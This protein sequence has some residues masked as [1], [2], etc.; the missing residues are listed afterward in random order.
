MECKK[1]TANHVTLCTLCLSSLTWSTFPFLFFTLLHSLLRCPPVS[2]PILP[3]PAL[4]CS[5]P[6]WLP[7]LLAVCIYSRD[8]CSDFE[9][10]CCSIY[11]YFPF[12]SVWFEGLIIVCLYLDW[13]K[14]WGMRYEAFMDIQGA[15]DHQLKSTVMRY[16]IQRQSKTSP[17]IT[18]PDCWH[19]SFSR[20]WPLD[21]GGC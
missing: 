21:V 13:V 9:H 7:A 10:H 12:L 1:K 16:N 11:V 17:N 4:L 5:P 15:K 18:Y 8:H 14:I 6:L 19:C 2:T 3:I 20:F